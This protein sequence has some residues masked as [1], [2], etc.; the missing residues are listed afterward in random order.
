MSSSI[1]LHIT[2]SLVG[3][4]AL[5]LLSSRAWADDIVRYD[6]LAA[7]LTCAGGGPYC[8]SIGTTDTYE[9]SSGMMI[10]GPWSF[11]GRPLDGYIAVGDGSNQTCAPF[12]SFADGQGYFSQGINP[13]DGYADVAI[14]VPPE[15]SSLLLTITGLLGIAVFCSLR[16]RRLWRS[17]GG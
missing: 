10:V 12:C 16:R 17:V 5:G 3:I 8:P 1:L 14:P 15:P 13:Q 2:K 6:I 7:T 11:F 4:A 9:L